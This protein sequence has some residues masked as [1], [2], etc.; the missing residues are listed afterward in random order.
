MNAMSSQIRI[1]TKWAFLA[2]SLAFSELY[3]AD[4]ALKSAETAKRSQ[5]IR[6]SG[7]CP[8]LTRSPASTSPPRLPENKK[9]QTCRDVSVPDHMQNTTTL[10]RPQ[11]KTLKN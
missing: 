3:S 6:S 1:P 8:N 4:I 11:K 2:A 9:V 7:A 5:R 10:K